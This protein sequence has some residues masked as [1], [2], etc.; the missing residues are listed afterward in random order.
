MKPHFPFIFAI[1]LVVFMSCSTDSENEVVVPDPNPETQKI[2]FPPIDSDTWEK[3]TLAGL[4]WNATAE[5][6]LYDFLDERGTDAFIILKDG[7]LV[8]EKYF[9]DFTASTPHAWNS[10]GKTLTAMTTGIAQQE[11][12]LSITD[13]SRRFLGPGWSMLTPEQEQNIT[14]QH[15]L[16]MTSGLDYS[17]EDVFCTDKDCLSY[18]NEPGS[19]WFYHNGPY[20]LLDQIITSAAGMD[21]EDYFTAKIKNRIGMTGSWIRVGYNN[22]YFSNARSMARFGLLNLNEGVWDGTD[23]VSDQTFNA[24]MKNTSQEHNKA[25]GYLWWLNGKDSYRVPGGEILF[26]GELIPNAPDDLIAGLGKNDQKLYIVP[27]QGLVIVRMGE[28]AGETLLGP[29]SFDNELWSKII[30]VID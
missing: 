20:T 27:S 1:F 8:I 17:V 2:Y 4:E 12:F 14:I 16:T 9:G 21:F 6:P 19:F 26:S 13:S 29:S 10:A 22:V 5:Q 11:G 28:D 23:I 25:Y 30:N 18:K 15:H 3:S 24:A 7:K